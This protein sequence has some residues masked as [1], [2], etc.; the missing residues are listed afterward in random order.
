VFLLARTP[1]TLFS[2]RGGA[3]GS[4]TTRGSHPSPRRSLDHRVVVSSG[5]H[6]RGVEVGSI[7]RLS[8]SPFFSLHGPYRFPVQSHNVRSCSE[9]RHHSRQG[10]RLT[11]G[12]SLLHPSGVAVGQNSLL[13]RPNDCQIKACGG[14]EQERYGPVARG[15]KTH[16]SK[17][18][19]E[20][21]LPRAVSI[22][23]TSWR[24]GRAPTASE[25]V[26]PH[27]QRPRDRRQRSGQR[28]I[29]PMPS[30]LLSRLDPRR[31]SPF[32]TSCG[33]ESYPLRRN[34]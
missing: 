6:S 17:S 28:V 34:P 21:L 15:A 23:F 5:P 25:G 16:R 12:A 10:E 32:L 26:G 27:V 19:R 2:S 8:S 9:L 4:L 18:P 24:A 13:P 7:E 31:R 29:R 22:R 1:T 20:P 14:P 11:R 3:P 33:V 30:P